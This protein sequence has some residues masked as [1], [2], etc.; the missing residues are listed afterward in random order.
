MNKIF[1]RILKIW[2]KYVPC[3][4]YGKNH[5]RPGYNS[6]YFLCPKHFGELF[7]YMTSHKI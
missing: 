3:A 7:Y 6:G 1:R 2:D 5:D 4:S